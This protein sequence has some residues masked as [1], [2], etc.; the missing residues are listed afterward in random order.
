MSFQRQYVV[1]FDTGQTEV[2][3]AAS[4]YR[5][6]DDAAQRVGLDSDQVASVH[7]IAVQPSSLAGSLLTGMLLALV[8][9]GIVF[10]IAALLGHWY[11]TECGIVTILVVGFILGIQLIDDMMFQRKLRHDDNVAHEVSATI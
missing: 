11:P 7:V 1:T 8:A 5:A 9:I 10:G 4:E 2:V 3:L 6:V